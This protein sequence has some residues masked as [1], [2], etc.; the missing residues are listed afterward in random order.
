M[1]ILLVEDEQK[2]SQALSRGLGLEG[3]TVDTIADGKKALTRIS[4]HRS[5][6][7][8]VILG[9]MLPS[10]DGYEICKQMREMGITVTILV[11]TARNETDTKVKLLT[12]GAGDHPLQPFSFSGLTPPLRGLLRRP[13]DT[14]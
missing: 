11:L 7:D 13:P 8:A 1:K 6:Y 12:A 2:L 5:D 4:L 14:T 10:L 9:L 3:Y